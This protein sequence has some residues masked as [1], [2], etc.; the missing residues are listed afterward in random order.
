FCGSRDGRSGVGSSA[1]LFDG[2]GGRKSLDEIHVWLFHSIQKLPRIS[3]EAFDVAT[4]SLGIKRVESQR[5]L[6][7]TTQTG[8]DNQ[9][10]SWNFHVEVL[11]IVLASTANLD[12]FRTHSDHKRR[13]F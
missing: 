7:R 6:S 1:A 8:N 13:T 9:L 5:R 3:G 10:S 11:E 12:N 2:N 4:L